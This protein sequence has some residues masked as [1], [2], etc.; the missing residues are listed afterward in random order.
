MPATK[1]GP[2]ERCPHCRRDVRRERDYACG[3]CGRFLDYLYRQE[4]LNPNVGLQLTVAGIQAEYRV[5]TW[6]LPGWLP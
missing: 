6:P 1:P 5:L 4:H 2:S 3:R